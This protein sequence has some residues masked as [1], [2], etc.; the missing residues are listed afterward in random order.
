MK[1][2]F[3]MHNNVLT[4]IF[5]TTLSITTFAVATWITLKLFMAILNYI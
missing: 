3:A 5:E 4:E 1:S 2:L